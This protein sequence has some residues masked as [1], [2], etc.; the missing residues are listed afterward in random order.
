[1]GFFGQ[2]GVGFVA[3]DGAA[4]LGVSSK[5]LSYFRIDWAR[6]LNWNCPNRW[7]VNARIRTEAGRLVPSERPRTAGMGAERPNLAAATKELGQTAGLGPFHKPRARHFMEFRSFEPEPYGK[8]PEHAVDGRNPLRTTLNPWPP[9]FVGMYRG[10]ILPG[11]PRWCESD[12]VHPQYFQ[13]APN[14]GPAK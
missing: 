7:H 14:A 5:T 10:I 11:F 6:Q 3:E 12:V 1:M 4:K 8:A 9:S 13:Y 2:I